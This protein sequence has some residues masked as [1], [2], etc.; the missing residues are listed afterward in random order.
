MIRNKMEKKFEG[1][2]LCIDALW[3]KMGLG[4]WSLKGIFPLIS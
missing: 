4:A 3:K 1:T 2:N